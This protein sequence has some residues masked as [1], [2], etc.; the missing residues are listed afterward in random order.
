M[1]CSRTRTERFIPLIRAERKEPGDE[2]GT[3]DGR[4]CSDLRGHWLGATAAAQILGV[5]RSS[6]WKFGEAGV[7]ERTVLGSVSRPVYVFRRDDVY[8]LA[9]LRTADERTLTR[10]E[11]RVARDRS[12]HGTQRMIFFKDG[13]YSPSRR[14]GNRP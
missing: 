6:V 7:L 1:R 4:R 14:A 5:H 12:L 11:R 3:V 13:A 8:Q 10:L 9:F 2:F